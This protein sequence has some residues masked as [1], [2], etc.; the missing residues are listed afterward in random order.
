MLTNFA[1]R[2]IARAVRDEGPS[3]VGAVRRLRVPRCRGRFEA[4][5]AVVRMQ[6]RVG[7]SR[8]AQVARGQVLAP[9]AS[10]QAGSHGAVGLGSRSCA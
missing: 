2:G 10:I 6:A 7:W 4:T 1:E 3:G 5:D 9:R 8:R